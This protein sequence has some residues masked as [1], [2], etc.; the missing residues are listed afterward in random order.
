MVIKN[1]TSRYPQLY[2]YLKVSQ[3]VTNFCISQRLHLIARLCISRVRRF[4]ALSNHSAVCVSNRHFLFDAVL[5]QL[6][7]GGIAFLRNQGSL[8]EQGLSFVA[9]GVF[10]HLGR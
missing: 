3:R 2:E 4:C 6:R 5:P 8:D 9:V 10:N 7:V 1:E